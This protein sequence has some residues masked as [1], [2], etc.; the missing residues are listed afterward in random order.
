MTTPRDLLV[1]ALDTADGRSVGQGELSLALAG[2]ELVDL[3]EAEAVALE[4]DRIVPGPPPASGDTLS[5]AAVEALVTEPPYE[6]VED[7]L[8]RRGRGLSS[9]YVAAME[10]DG[11][12]TR[13][14]RGLLRR[15]EPTV[16]ADS[17]LRR[18]ASDRWTSGEP[19][20]LGLAAAAGVHDMPT[21]NPEA[22]ADE[23]VGTVLAAVD[24][25]VTELE[26]VRH[27]RGIEQAAFDNVW[28]AP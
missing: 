8:W 6:T 5:A 15:A 25:A 26:A 2:A 11:Q 4:G 7:W 27:R 10:A 17:P 22:L 19:V 1:L 18:R 16:P 24:D 28:R 12:V 23:A 21:E 14:R 13:P 3:I 9:A 20:L